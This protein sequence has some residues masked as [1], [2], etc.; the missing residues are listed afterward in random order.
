MTCRLHAAGI[1]RLYFLISVSVHR[2]STYH[3]HLHRILYRTFLAFMTYD[4][5]T[6]HLLTR[7]PKLIPPEGYLHPITTSSWLYYIATITLIFAILQYANYLL[8]G[9]F[10]SFDVMPMMFMFHY[11]G[12]SSMVNNVSVLRLGKII[13][14]LHG[15]IIFAFLSTYNQNLR[16]STIEPFFE[17]LPDH[18]S[19]VNSRESLIRQFDFSTMATGFLY[20]YIHIR[21]LDSV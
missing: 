3:L 10:D 7:H 1:K 15:F 20:E 18:I 17:D 11:D 19:E 8:F 6:V 16:S 4:S 9:K 13:I 14:I 21:K 2:H 5:D 12:C